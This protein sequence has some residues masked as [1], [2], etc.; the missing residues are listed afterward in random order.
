MKSLFSIFTVSIVMMLTGC[1]ADNLSEATVTI[2]DGAIQ[3]TAGDGMVV[4]RGIPFAV[5][6]VGELRWKAPQPVVQRGGVLLAQKFAPAPVQ[7]VTQWMGDIKMSE[8]CLYLNVWTP[9][10]TTREKLPVMVWIYGG[11]FSNG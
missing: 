3:G 5:P 10:R 2:K 4:F 6:P 9:A 7:T 1:N 8:D 11:G